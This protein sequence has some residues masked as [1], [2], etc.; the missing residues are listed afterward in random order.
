M[1][2]TR[3]S[4]LILHQSPAELPFSFKA[5]RLLPFCGLLS[6]PHLSLQN[7]V[8]LSDNS[9]GP[10]QSAADFPASRYKLIEGNQRLSIP[11][12]CI[13]LHPAWLQHGWL[14]ETSQSGIELLSPLLLPSWWFHCLYADGGGLLSKRDNRPYNGKQTIGTGAWGQ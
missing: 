13:C 10:M 14:L 2:L 11:L 5:S 1:L 7:D 4:N 12:A 8:F 9:G 3:P 6:L